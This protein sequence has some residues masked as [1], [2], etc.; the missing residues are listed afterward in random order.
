MVNIVLPV[1]FGDKTEQ[2]L[3]GAVK[4]A[5]QVNGRIYLIHVA[6][7]DIGFA[8]GDMGFQYFP[9]VEENEIREELVQLNK[10]QQRI[11]AHEVECEH[12]LKQGIAKDIILEHAED[13]K[14]DFI[15]MGSHG[16][17]GI[18]DVFVGSL[19]K[20]ITKDSKVPVLVLPIHD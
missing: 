5:K 10:I 18:Y 14:A 15:V 12:I 17:S 19:T 16:R 8:I 20:G 1:D 4:F 3:E 7:S 2:L 6:P 11:L 13:K 9:E